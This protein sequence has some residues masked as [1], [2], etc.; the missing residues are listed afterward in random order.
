MLL[1]LERVLQGQRLW[2]P[3]HSIPLT[4]LTPDEK[5]LLLRTLGE[6][7]AIIEV[8]GKTERTAVRTML[9]GVWF[10]EEKTG[11]DHFTDTID[12]GVLPS[13]AVDR[14]A[15]L[16]EARLLLTSFSSESVAISAV[17]QELLEKERKWEREGMPGSVNLHLH[18]FLPLDYGRLA[19]FL[20]PPPLIGWWKEGRNRWWLFGTQWQDLWRVEAR[21]QEGREMASFLEI[22]RYPA[23]L[24]FPPSTFAVSARRVQRLLQPYRDR[25]LE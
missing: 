23:A 13:F 3:P 9:S 21:T 1:T 7:A 19:S 24:T 8:T 17:R 11:E 6:G 10:T 22:G 20:G 5:E 2:E 25:L 14:M 4:N 18:P 15:D 16:P 12:V